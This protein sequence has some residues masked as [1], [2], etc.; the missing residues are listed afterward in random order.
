MG[1]G[2]KKISRFEHIGTIIG[3]VLDDFY[4]SVDS[5]LSEVQ[6]IW[7]EIVGPMAAQNARPRAFEGKILVVHATS[8]SWI[9]ELQFLK[10]EIL[11]RI[12]EKIGANRV[13]EIRF[14]IGPI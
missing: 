14:K 12:S 1:I 13:S 3:K 10:G 8:S 9:Q 7:P 5:P 11:Q 4:K 6:L 2:V